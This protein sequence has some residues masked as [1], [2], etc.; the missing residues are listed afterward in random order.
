VALDESVTSLSKYLSNAIEKADQS[1][2]H[3]WEQ[4]QVLLSDN[5]RSM[6]GHQTHLAEQ[7]NLIHQM[8]EKT[9]DLNMFESALAKNDE[10]IA[11][12]TRL[13][14]ALAE[15]TTAFLESAKPLERETGTTSQETADL[16][17]ADSEV[18]MMEL[19]NMELAN[20]EPVETESFGVDMEKVESAVVEVVDRAGHD[21]LA[22][23]AVSRPAVVPKESRREQALPEIVM[24]MILSFQSARDEADEKASA[25]ATAQ[26]S[27]R[28]SP[29]ARKAA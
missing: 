9:G 22:D 21:R 29:F 11:Q 26:S 6:S 5:A 2:S 27:A 20:M 4:W 13:R 8:L 1:M 18:A 24:P 3:R 12:T 7:T 23:Q 15:L 25:D 19:A 16:D 17:T 10:A 28:L 14:D